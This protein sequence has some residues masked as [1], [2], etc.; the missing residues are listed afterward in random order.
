[1]RDADGPKFLN[2]RVGRCVPAV[3][4]ASTLSGRTQGGGNLLVRVPLQ[5]KSSRSGRR[6]DR[7][8]TLSGGLFFMV[9]TAGPS[10]PS[11]IEEKGSGSAA[12]GGGSRNSS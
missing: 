9:G 1:M 11:A 4:G 8:R 3:T 7:T 10:R 5:D 2:P 12:A 6:G